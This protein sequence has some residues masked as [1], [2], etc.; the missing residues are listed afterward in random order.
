MTTTTD[1]KVAT[2]K[3]LLRITRAIS[4]HGRSC[5]NL[6]IEYYGA[7]P[8]RCCMS[9]HVGVALEP[10]ACTQRDTITR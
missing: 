8:C 1:R 2:L 9:S 5:R 7:T 3:V 10:S 6:Q 4:G